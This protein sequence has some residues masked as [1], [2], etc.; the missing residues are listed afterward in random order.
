[1]RLA[2]RIEV[3]SATRPLV[4]GPDFA[5]EAARS[6]EVVIVTIPEGRV[7]DLPKDLLAGIAEDVVVVDTGNYYPR[8]R[9]GRINEIEAGLPESRWV[10]GQMEARDQDIN[11]NLCR[12]SY[13]K[14][15]SGQCS[16]SH[17]S[18]GCRG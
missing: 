6:G 13:E 5:K 1:M 8:E 12:T 2:G 16:K 11:N 17:R 9:D 10:E 18:A 14:R 15:P 4:I 7:P 3:K